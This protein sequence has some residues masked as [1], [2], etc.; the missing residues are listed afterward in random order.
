MKIHVLG[1]PGHVGGANTELWHTLLLWRSHGCQVTV[2]PT[3]RADPDWSARCES[4]GCTVQPAS[5]SSFAA[6]PGVPIVSFCNTQ[7]FGVLRRL[8][9]GRNPTV[10]VPCMN[11]LTDRERRRYQAGFLPSAVVC[12]SQYQISEIQR[13]LLGYGLPK[14]RI[15]QIRGAFDPVSIPFT[16]KTP[17]TEFVVGRISRADPAKF[18]PCLWQVLDRVRSRI[19]RP[20]K[21]RVLGWRPGLA[22]R[23]GRPPEWAE[24]FEPGSVDAIEFLRSLDVLY[25]SG[26]TAENW[27]RV[28]LEAMAA[29]VPIV[30]DRQGGWI[31]MSDGG[32][33]ASL[34]SDSAEAE[35]A[36][37]DH[38]AM[39]ADRREEMVRSARGAV[40]DS[41]GSTRGLWLRWRELFLD[42]T[43]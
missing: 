23:I 17:G 40:D 39:P 42:L 36:L 25:Q 41:L 3:W 1:L 21:A 34:V 31:E 16:P 4:I 38:A 8:V 26:E 13:E 14:E 43:T 18:R 30:T 9:P 37:V 6:G 29:G 10:W 28:G 5:I 7:F 32:R 15:Y 27:P 12:Q 33:L 20:L 19:D 22:K 24:L 11:F 35:E 2:T